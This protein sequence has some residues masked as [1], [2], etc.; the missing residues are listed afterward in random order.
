MLAEELPAQL[1]MFAVKI[2]KSCDIVDVCYKV[3]SVDMNNSTLFM[4]SRFPNKT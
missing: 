3:K 4:T 1:N 2:E